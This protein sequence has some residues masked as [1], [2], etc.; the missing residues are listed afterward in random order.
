MR[1]FAV[2]ND[3]AQ[4]AGYAAP[5]ARGQSNAIVA[6]LKMMY[7]DLWSISYVEAHCTRVG[8]GIEVRGLI[9]AFPAAGGKARP[10]LN[11]ARGSVKW[12]IAHANCA[13]GAT[14]FIK[15]LMLLLSHQL[16]PVANIS[17]LNPKISLEETPWALLREP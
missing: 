8:D 7:E 5:S 3:C 11:V 6:A 15:T 2:T 12:N 14:G 10:D 4:K 13:A 9:H 16:V 17:K 1:G